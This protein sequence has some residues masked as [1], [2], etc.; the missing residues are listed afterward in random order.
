VDHIPGKVFFTTSFEIK[1]VRELKSAE[2]LFLLL[3][4]LSAPTGKP[5]KYSV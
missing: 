5:T 4:R 2:R 3:K 1:Q